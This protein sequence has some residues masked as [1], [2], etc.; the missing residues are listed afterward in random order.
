M[1]MMLTVSQ[2][3]WSLSRNEILTPQRVNIRRLLAIT[4]PSAI[5]SFARMKDNLSAGTSLTPVSSIMHLTM[6]IP[7]RTWMDVQLS[8]IILSKHSARL[9]RKWRN[10][11]STWRSRTICCSS[12]AIRSTPIMSWKISR[13]P[14]ISR[15][16]AMV[17]QTAKI[18]AS[19]TTRT[20]GTLPY[21][22]LVTERKG[23]TWR[24]KLKILITLWVLV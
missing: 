3:Q 11:W 17:T 1:R 16:W 9:R 19:L 15:N 8:A 12:C 21:S 20:L 5:V 7:R 24:G 6:P 23:K 14:I 10:R 4:E 2:S 13:N 18:V 22:P